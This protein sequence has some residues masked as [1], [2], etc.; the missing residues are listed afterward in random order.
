MQLLTPLIGKKVTVFSAQGETERQDIGILEGAEGN[1]ITLR[2]T[3]EVL[4][5]TIHRIRMIKPF[6]PH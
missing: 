6:D 2:K 4:Y 5:F 1:F 3:E